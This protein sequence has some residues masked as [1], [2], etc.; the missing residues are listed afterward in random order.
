MR[1]SKSIATV[2]LAAASVAIP[3]AAQFATNTVSFQ[4]GVNGY[5]SV[6][7]RLISSRG[8]AFEF[9]AATGRQ[10]WFVDGFDPDEIAL[11]RFDN[12]IGNN[13]LQIPAGATIV[14]AN[15]QV[16]T[17]PGSFSTNAQT[18][19]SFGVAGLTTPFTTTST[20]TDFGSSGPLVSNGR[21]TPAY[22]GFVDTVDGQIDRDQTVQANVT[23]IVD[24]WSKG[25]L[26]NN[27]LVIQAGRPVLTTDGWAIGTS[28]NNT[29]ARRPRLSVTYTTTPIETVSYQQGVNGYTGSVMSYVRQDNNSNNGNFLSPDGSNYNQ[30][31]I[32]GPAANSPDDQAMLRFNNIFEDEGGFV[33]RNAEILDAAI[34]ITSGN[35]SGDVQSEGPWDM[36]Q[37]LVDWDTDANDSGKP[38]LYGEFGG[39]LGPDESA[40]VVAPRLGTVGAVYQDS[41]AVYDVTSLFNAWRTGAAANYGVNIQAGSVIPPGG[42]SPVSNSNGWQISWTGAID[43]T[44]RP[45]LVVRIKAAD[46]VVWN[47]DADG[48]WD[49]S[50][51]WLTNI[52]PDAV[53]LQVEFPDVISAQRTINVTDTFTVGSVK[54]AAPE[55]YVFSGP[56]TIEFKRGSGASVNVTA[57]NHAINS[58][59]LLSSGVTFDVAAGSTVDLLGGVSGAGQTLAK[60]GEG[61]VNVSTLDIAGVSISGGTLNLL[62][63]Q[64]ALVLNG[65]TTINTGTLNLNGAA[66]SFGALSGNG[67][68]DLGGQPLNITGGTSGTFTGTLTNTTTLAKSGTGT[69]TIATDAA[70]FTGPVTVATGQLRIGNGGT[71]GGLTN[72]VVL[73]DN[74]TIAF[75]RSDDITYPGVISGTGS[76]QKLGDGNLTLA[77]AQTFNGPTTVSAGVLTT[78]VADSLPNGQLIT[79][80]NNATLVF[81]GSDEVGPITG[82]GTVSIPAGATL[83]ILDDLETGFDGSFAGEGNLVKRGALAYTISSTYTLSGDVTVEQDRLIIEAAQSTTNKLEAKNGTTIEITAGT[84]GG[85]NEQL[86]KSLVLNESGALVLNNNDFGVD[87]TGES[88]IATI[89]GYWLNSQI[90]VTELT[91]GL[92]VYL[93]I[94]EAAD[95]G[96]TTLGNFTIDDT[97]VIAKYTYVGDANLDGQVDALDYER[98]DLAIGN[99]GVFGTAQGDLNYDGAVDALD[100]E[101]VDLNIGNGVGAPLATIVVPEPASFGL[102]ALAG[103]LLARR[104][105]A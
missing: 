32:D 30:T 62:P 40:G 43:P 74:G 11:I 61:T 1:Q 48:N 80:G 55:G 97:T 71:V 18:G 34:V 95:L 69:F 100:Y 73:S 90:T 76:L 3:A 57:G 8:S 2:L 9:T 58:A 94:A 52:V 7:E 88:P 63:G 59:V 38:T 92:P 72:D 79:L 89:I 25:T 39:G 75:N 49:L 84:F 51:N 37:M 66:P 86:V 99:I 44:A 42:G 41:K 27:G 65:L 103:G 96:L 36:H 5:T 29:V 12:I 21:T 35:T 22:G 67:S 64:P 93:A 23:Q 6:S 17:A 82:G 78:S 31:F 87:Y 53:N 14:S 46:K 98:I 77:Q 50:G 45:Q 104:R 24:S 68:L 15:L 28:F 56:G 26:A 13:P 4:V 60:T 85:V 91:N 105:R 81:G 101:Q 47:A 20:Y 54:L 83:T 102:L 19:G 70:T 33:P 10:N 16:T